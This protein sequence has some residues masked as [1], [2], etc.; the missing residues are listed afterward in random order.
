MQRCAYRPL[1]LERDA[2]QGDGELVDLRVSA[3]LLRLA[4]RTGHV[5]GAP[6]RRIAADTLHMKG[7]QKGRDIEVGQYAVGL[8]V[9]V[10]MQLRSGL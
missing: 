1:G 4:Q 7:A 10:A 5:D 2:L 6:D 3:K 9:E 8:G